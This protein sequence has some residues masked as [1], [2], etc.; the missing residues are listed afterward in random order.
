LSASEPETDYRFLLD[1]SVISPSGARE[2]A[3][4]R[5]RYLGN[6]SD[7]CVVHMV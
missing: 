1:L 5:W 2:I 4:E 7:T 6:F 3:G